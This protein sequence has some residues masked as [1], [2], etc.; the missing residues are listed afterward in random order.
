MLYD[1]AMRNYKLWVLGLA[2]LAAGVVLGGVFFVSKAPT[3]KPRSPEQVVAEF[4]KL[5]FA[6][7]VHYQTRWL[8]VPTLQ[9]PCDM[10]MLQQIITEIKPDFILETGTYKGGG[11]LFLASILR[12]VNG[13]GKVLTVDIEPQ[14]TLASRYPVFNDA[15]EVF[16]GSSVSEDVVKAIAKRVEGARV[17]V[18]LDSDHA[19]SHVLNEL[20]IY[21]RFVSVHSYLVVEDTAHNGHPLPHDYDGGGPMQAVR[22][23]LLR[24]KN[25]VPDQT[26]ERFLLTFFPQGY[27]K[28]VS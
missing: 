4:T 26:R 21:S 22:E 13:Q 5:Y 17:M 10:W 11:A 6:T 16:T 12:L 15:V 9:N 24:H 20:E 1:T 28:R 14:V 19:K 23:F 8:G 7:G 25:F 18:I 3:D 27:L 2:V